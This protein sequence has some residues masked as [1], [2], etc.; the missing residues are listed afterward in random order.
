MSWLKLMLKSNRNKE[1][2][3][4]LRSNLKERRKMWV[5]VRMPYRMLRKP[6]RSTKRSQRRCHR[7]IWRLILSLISRLLNSGTKSEG[8]IKRTRTW[9]T[10]LRWRMTEFRVT[11]LRCPLCLIRKNLLKIWTRLTDRVQEMEFLRQLATRWCKHLKLTTWAHSL[12]IH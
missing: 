8:W 10:K 11:F 4:I 1:T 2:Y 3:R 7:Q 5:R 12:S 9:E 6:T